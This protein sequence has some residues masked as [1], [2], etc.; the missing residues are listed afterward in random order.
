MQLK[1]ECVHSLVK[2]NEWGVS[3]TL[4]KALALLIDRKVE[5][6]GHLWDEVDTVLHS[7]R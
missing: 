3:V 1:K 2:I 5:S 4:L 7:N 6:V